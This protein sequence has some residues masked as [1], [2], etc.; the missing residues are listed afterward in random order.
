MWLGCN[1]E[2]FVYD[3]DAAG[4]LPSKEVTALGFDFC[5]KASGMPPKSYCIIVFQKNNT[6]L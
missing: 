1:Q 6:Y 5:C 2:W 3:K 4:D